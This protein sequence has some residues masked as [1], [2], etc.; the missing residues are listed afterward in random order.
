MLRHLYTRMK[1]FVLVGAFV[2]TSIYCLAGYSLE[3]ALA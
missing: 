1:E 3:K 2:F